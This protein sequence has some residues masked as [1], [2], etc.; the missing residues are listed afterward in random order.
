MISVVIPLYNQ[1]QFVAQAIDSILDQTYSPIEIIVI[2]DG[3]S[4]DP[5][6]VLDKYRGKIQ[7]VSQEN[8][9]LAAARNAGIALARGDFVQFLDADDWLHPDKIRLQLEFMKKE[10]AAISYCE[11]LQYEQ[12][13]EKS[14][15]RYIG[16]LEDMFGHL[17]NFWHL[18][19]LPVHGILLKKELFDRFGPFATDLTACEDRH[20]FSRLAAGGVVFAYF[21]FIGGSRRVHG[22]S[23][24]R[25][26]FHIIGNILRYYQ[27][28][29]AELGDD[30]FFGRYGFSGYD[31]MCANLTYLYLVEVGRGATGKELLFIR[32]VMKENGIRR[33]TGPI[34]PGPRRFKLPLSLLKAYLNRFRLHVGNLKN[35]GKNV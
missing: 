23:M 18:Y 35:R 25:D 11:I 12:A 2:D 15:L 5:Q 4:D 21:P 34:P 19:P 28:L 26:R 16:P 30:Y 20:F 27:K 3:S 1:Q 6:P 7:V 29:N 31:L 32:Q 17:Y 10:R 13:S 24:N 8:Q 33:F 9:G 14:L 22:Q